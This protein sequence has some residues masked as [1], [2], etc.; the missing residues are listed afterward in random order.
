M[1]MGLDHRKENGCSQLSTELKNIVL[2]Q[3]AAV[4]LSLNK[5]MAAD[6]KN[7]AQINDLS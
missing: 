6:L 3:K 2:S 1:F 5:K 7:N 4:S